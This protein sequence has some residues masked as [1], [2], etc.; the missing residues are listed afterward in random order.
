[1]TP[2]TLLQFPWHRQLGI[3][4]EHERNEDGWLVIRG[5]HGW[6]HGSAVSA[7]LEA[8]KLASVDSV[9]IVVRP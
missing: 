2:G 9:A 4:V 5:S 3:I 1:M 8:L 7:F 6:L